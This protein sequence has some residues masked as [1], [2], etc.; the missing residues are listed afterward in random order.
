M[1]YLILYYFGI[2]CICLWAGILFYSF[3]DRNR[4]AERT[5]FHF[6]LTGLIMITAIG[7]WIVLIFP[8]GLFSLF[9]I[10]CLF[11][12]CSFFR[13]MRIRNIFSNCLTGLKEKNIWFF[14]CL[15][16]FYLMILVLNAGP[17]LMDDTDSYHIQMVKWIQEYGSV[18]GIAN[19]HLR[20]GFN[21]SWFV[22]IALFS[23]PFHGLNIYTSLN[24]LL[25]VWLSYYLLET[26][27]NSIKSNPAKSNGIVAA[28]FI[29]FILCL[30]NWPMIRGSAMNA[31]YDFIST[32]CI[33]LLFMDLFSIQKE[34]PVEWLIWPAYMFTVRLMNFPLLI[35]SLVYIYR[36]LKPFSARKLFLSF[37]AVGF[38]IIPFLIRNSILSG[39]P[40]FPFYQLDFFSFDWKADKMNLVEISRYI[41]YFNRVNPM[42]QPLSVTEKL[43]FPNWIVSWYTY[44]F[45]FDKLI[46]ALAFLGYL[47]LLIR[48][49]KIKD[50]LLRIFLFVM[51]C[52]LI[53]WFFLAPDPRF[54]YGSLLFG[55][56]AAMT[57]LPPVKGSWSGM[58][59]YTLILTSFFVLAYA[60]LKVVR[61]NDYRNF[62]AP[63]R[64]PV[65]AV[66]TIM[67]DHIQMH[68]PERVLNNWNPRC[69]DLELP[70]LYRPDPR[71][72][73]R[74]RNISN[75]FRLKYSDKDIFTGSE[76]KISE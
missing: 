50:H 28:G 33:I 66:K 67:V 3:I 44:L 42:F 15:F 59:K 9:F 40:F 71:L 2:S 13:R 58:M 21:S 31:N 43:G 17:T 10:L 72:E 51:V 32:C 1:L 16:C 12:L 48:V 74:G 73:A 25:S 8:V 37:F 24:G 26:I 69:Y 46:I 68:I 27:F 56:F 53:S 14:A 65:P 61:D 36:F 60:V 75:G 30:L 38:I 64:I 22:S 7:Q 18:P 4:G 34:A 47:I 70:C 57:G 20:F 45:R 35:L 23:Y 19:L 49:K 39:Y 11:I 29:L 76:Y 52:Q 54:V 41:K 55:I 62:L 63:H 6:L 5:F